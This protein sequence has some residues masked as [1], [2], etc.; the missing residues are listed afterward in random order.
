M[1]KIIK[2]KIK[3][4]NY[5]KDIILETG[6]LA[7]QS[8]GSIIVK[9][10]KTIILSTVVFGK[11]IE[12]NI[13]F[14][15]LTIDYREKYFAGGKIP[16][17]YI[18]REGKPTDEEIIIMRMVD[19]LIR[20]FIPKNIT[21]EIQIMINLLSYDKN[22][23]SPD[24]LVG[25]A[26]SSCLITSGIPNYG[27]VSQIR[28]G[29]I[30]DKYILNPTID[31]IKKSKVNFVIGGSEDNIVMIEGDMN[32]IN[33][34]E[35]IKILKISHKF[36]KY[37]I[38]EQIK[39]Y[40]K[41]IKYKKIKNKVFK[42][43]K[44]KKIKKYI[45]KYF[46]KKILLFIRK[47]TNKKKR[48][49][50]FDN[51]FLKFKNKINKNIFIKNEILLKKY[52]NYYKK[53]AVN[54]I[55]KLNKRLDGRFIHQIRNISGI[56]NY[57]PG[58]HG[59]AL[60]TRGET[61]CLTT[62]T[63]GNS[64]DINRIDNLVVE[65]NEKFYLHYNFHPFS[66]GEVKQIRGISRR[67]IGH[68]YLA[69]KALKIIIPKNP[70]TIR[71]VS[72]ILESNG[73]SSMAT[74]CGGT[75]ALI[76]AG[77]K[78]KNLVGGLAIGIILLKKKIVI[79]PDILG[80]EDHYGEMDFKITRTIKGITSCQMDIKN[81]KINLFNKNLL[82]KILNISKSYI[83]LIISKLI[84]ILVKSKSNFKFIKPKYSIIKIPKE[85]IGVI[86][87]GGGKN[88]QDIEVNTN[89]NIIITEINNL[90]VIEIFGSKDIDINKAINNIK[91]IIFIPIKDNIYKANIKKINKTELIFTISNIVKSSL[92]LSKNQ[93][94]KIKNK[95]KKK[96]IIYVKYLGI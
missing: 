95:Y 45:K 87:G 13:N 35:F 28:I 27:P 46:Y 58:A 42:F 36:I 18:K 71:I 16:G 70:Y 23:V 24:G 83:N 78:I 2:R 64:L 88:I 77:I 30:N 60:F 84:K 47:K 81:S 79:L 11:I 96:D 69:K 55:I 93:Y 49:T 19:R 12:E 10:G 72:E 29:K 21:R 31:Q 94:K 50:K 57:L 62:V 39:F 22:V 41:T 52:Y 17:G 73:S 92:L 20:P 25:L 75:L 5:S 1:F 61:Q 90:G 38:K 56:I 44:N 32:Q 76:D 74:V 4:K 48:S 37:Q 3:L 43:Y 7:N 80:E 86:I 91:R 26:A 85:Y 15:P 9:L 68:G 54:K 51:L 34:K 65:S 40:F 53:K 59:S 6:L 67:E 89:T 33:N 8:N 14:V 66:T 63:L 82:K